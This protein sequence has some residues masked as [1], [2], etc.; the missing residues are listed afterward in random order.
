V[1]RGGCREEVTGARGVAGVQAQPFLMCSA[2]H[3]TDDS[4]AIR[5]RDAHP[6]TVIR[7][8]LRGVQ[9]MALQGLRFGKGANSWWHLFPF[10]Y[11]G[12]LIP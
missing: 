1:V 6:S 5:C 12:L 10:S 9:P 2:P 7:T 4:R 3:Q 8:M 11:K